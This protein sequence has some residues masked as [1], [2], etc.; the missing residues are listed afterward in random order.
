MYKKFAFPVRFI[1]QIRFF[2]A[3]AIK[4]L[5]IRQG[6]VDIVVELVD[7][8]DV[9][10]FNKFGNSG[11]VCSAKVKDET[12]QMVLSLWNDDIDKVN[13]GDKVHIINGYVG[14]WQ[15]EPQL[16]TGKFGQLE[17]VEKGT[18]QASVSKPAPAPETSMP[19]AASEKKKE[20][21]TKEEN[22]DDAEVSEESIDDLY[23]DTE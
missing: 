22:W 1:N 2:I 19:K 6:K 17:I 7:K 3:M 10:A 12:G 15:G 16:S 23:D 21:E 18:G 11:K 20:F 14:E 5:Q 9:R 4:D 8:G 13:V